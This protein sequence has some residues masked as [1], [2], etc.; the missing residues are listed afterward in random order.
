MPALKE[1]LIDPKIDAVEIDEM[2]VSFQ[3]KQNKLWLWLAVSRYTGQILSAC[4]GDRSTDSLA[5]LWD[6]V[7]QRYHRRLVYTDGYV[8]YNQFFSAWQHRQ[9][10]KGDGGTCT[11]EGVNNALRQR[12]ANLVRRCCSIARDMDRFWDR[13]LILFHAHNRACQKRWE[14]R[15]AELTQSEP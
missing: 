1:T 7:P 2:C 8:I 12:G 10:E 6:D 4:L 9:C 3:T 14:R 15:R 5:G 11:V 13:L